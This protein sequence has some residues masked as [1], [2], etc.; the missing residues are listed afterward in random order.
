MWLKLSPSNRDP[1][2]ISRFYL[3]GVEK[4]RGVFIHVIVNYCDFV[5]E[6]CA[7]IIR[8][9]HGTE[10]PTLAKIHIVFRM[11]HSDDLEGSKSFIY[12][13]STTNILSTHV[14]HT[15]IIHDFQ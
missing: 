7:R 15:L 6:G 12:G 2:V 14:L 9:D 3:E 5:C 1:K 4:S 11:E 10:N 13:P 8:A